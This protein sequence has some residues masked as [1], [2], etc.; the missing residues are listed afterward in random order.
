MGLIG[1]GRMGQIHATALSSR[2]PSA[3]LACVV[4]AD[5]KRAADVAARCA[6]P[7]SS[8]V[9]GL[10]EDPTVPAVVL[11]TPTATH[12]DL[13]VRAARAGKHVFCEKPLSLQRSA[14][15]SALEA[16]ETAG[17]K[18]QVG[19][20]RRFDPDWAAVHDRIVAGELGR[21]YLFR[22][23]LR[24]MR[25][26][27]VEYLAG[28][29]GFFLDVTIHDL[30]VARWLVGEIVQISAHG[31]G[32]SDPGFAEIGD[33]DTAVVVLHFENGALGVIDNSRSAGYG[34]ECSTEIMGSSATA[35][36]DNPRA[37][38]YEWRTPGWAAHELPRDFEQRY[39]TAYALELEAFATC[40]RDDSAPRV[41]GRDALAAF[42]LASAADASWRAGLPVALRALREPA[43]VRYEYD[44]P[45]PGG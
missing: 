25:A 22:T 43:G 28:S 21:P 7:W 45:A 42:E 8:S 5:G 34:Y 39:P 3:E 23:S 29:G 44:E 17:V 27:R 26:P 13:V 4:D 16:V 14:T 41:T 12:A 31:V 9:D 2:C 40:V 38:N 20:H 18:L 11:A 33:V 36:I 30:D 6:V 19:F 1:L 10:L 35:R 15:L 37:R 32:L 24:D